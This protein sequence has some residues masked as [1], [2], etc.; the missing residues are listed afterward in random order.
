MA[1]FQQPFTAPI[2][3]T[4]DSS[5]VVPMGF[6]ALSGDGHMS[7]VFSRFASAEHLDAEPLESFTATVPLGDAA[8]QLLSTLVG[9]IAA[10]VAQNVVSG[11]DGASFVQ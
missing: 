4:F 1:G 8:G 10:A 9:I 6:S 11:L 7:V 3:I 5:I 2:G